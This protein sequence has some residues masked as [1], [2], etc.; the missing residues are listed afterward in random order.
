MK[1]EIIKIIEGGLS[2]DREKV[3]NY[4]NV[5]AEN[6]L[7]GG[8]TTFSN[9]IINAINNKKIGSIAFDSFSTK[10]V[11]YESRV[12]IVEIW[13]PNQ[14]EVN[15]VLNQHIQHELSEFVRQFTHRDIIASNGLAYSNSLLLYG[16]PGNGKT[17]VAKYMAN[18]MNKPLVIARFDALVSSLLGST[19]KNIR[20]LFDYVEKRD[21]ILFLDEFD[22]IAKARND[23]NELGELKRVVNSLLQNI[24]SLKGKN[25]IIAATN[26]HELL[27]SAI[28]R[29]F[30]RIIELKKPSDNEIQVFVNTLL[31]DRKT[32]LFDKSGKFVKLCRSLNGLSYSDIKTISENAI[33]KAIISKVATIKYVDIVYETFLLKNHD[34]SNEIE[35]V[36]FLSNHGVPQHEIHGQY[37][38][39]QRAIRRILKNEGENTDEQR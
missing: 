32:D 38:I 22:V 16:A 28:W 26:H 31:K 5:L 4:A 30:D 2:G 24:D 34:I 39:S 35:L 17:S 12:D 9:R 37:N 27:D 1:T 13:Y 7:K 18:Q 15:I 14:E 23:Q 36:S 11:D 21:C 6:Y 8:D 10:P 33:K 25:V 20:K 19:S 3:Y 29:R